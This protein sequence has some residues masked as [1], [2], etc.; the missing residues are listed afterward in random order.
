MVL[1]AFALYGVLVLIIAG[2]MIGLSAILGERHSERFTNQP[3]EGGIQSEG[4]ARVR[5]SI[6]FYMMAMFFV[7]FDL[8]SVFLYTWAV[9][10]R[11][12]GWLGYWEALIFMGVL[13]ATLVYLWRL[14]ALDWGPDTRRKTR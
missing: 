1:W 13:M 10:A 14:G 5:F 6:K 12:L 4:T 2:S 8:E 9:S 3:Y 7:V 11:G